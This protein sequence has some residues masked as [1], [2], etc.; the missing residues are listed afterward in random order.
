MK[1][2]IFFLIGLLTPQALTLLKIKQ[3]LFYFKFSVSKIF[4]K[5]N[6]VNYLKLSVKNSLA[7]QSVE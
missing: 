2:V 5:S 7:V 4:S 6:M 1:I 3:T